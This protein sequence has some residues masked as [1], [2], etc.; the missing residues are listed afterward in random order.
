LI[1]AL[2]P[3]V[4]AFAAAQAVNAVEDT[5]S[6]P[7]SWTTEE[8]A[9]PPEPRRGE[10]ELNEQRAKLALTITFHEQHAARLGD[11]PELVDPVGRVPRD[12]RDFAGPSDG[13]WVEHP[14]ATKIGKINGSPFL[15]LRC[16][17]P[18]GSGH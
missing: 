6:L 14:P 8:C 15:D 17:I 10:T 1:L 11:N 7:T 5:A 13:G 12:R 4:T 16:R 9:P 2:V 3:Q 18:A